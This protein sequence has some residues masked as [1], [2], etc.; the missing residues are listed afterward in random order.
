M[1]LLSSLHASTAALLLAAACAA[2]PPAPSTPLHLVVLHTNDIHGQLLPSRAGGGLRRV[3][4][5]VAQVRRALGPDEALLL[6]DGGDW[7]QGTPEGRVDGGAAFLGLLQRLGYDGLAVG[8][9]EL[10]HG[11]QHLEELLAGADLPALC[12]NVFDPRTGE[13][14][15]FGAPYRI[16]ERGGVRIALVGLLTTETAVIAHASA[17]GLVFAD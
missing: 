16:V 10:D 6:L 3:A 14:A 5:R 9:H 13:R 12:A 7:F 17:R 11:V 1:R 15:P 8:N 4:A 2:P